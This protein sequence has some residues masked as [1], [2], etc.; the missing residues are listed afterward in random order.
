MRKGVC[1]RCKETTW[2]SSRNLCNKCAEKAMAQYFEDMQNKSGDY[3]QRWLSQTEK[4]KG[5]K[6]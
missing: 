1:K 3:Y 5:D 6:E 4:V 2:I